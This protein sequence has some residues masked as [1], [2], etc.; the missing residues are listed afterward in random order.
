[1][2][3][4]E[5]AAGPIGADQLGNVLSHEHVFVL[6]PELQ[7][8]FPHEWG[9][10]DARVDDAVDKL[11]RLKSCGID[12]IIDPTAIGLGRYIPRIA[13]IARR[14]PVNIVVATGVYAFNDL[15]MYFRMRPVRDGRDV[16]TKRFVRDIQEGIGGTE[17]KAGVIK[18]ATDRPGLTPDVD[19]TLR[20]VAQA[21]RETGCPITTHTRA[22][23]RTGLLQ[24]A[25]FA[26]EG[27]DLERVLI[28]H[29]GDTDDMDYLHQL[30]EAGSYLGMDRFGIDGY[31][32]HERRIATIV[33][34][35]QE[36]YANRL[37][38]SHDAGCYMDVVDGEDA[39]NELGDVSN[40]HYEFISRTVLPDLLT[41]GVT[42][43]QVDLMMIE[44]PRAYLSNI[45]RGGY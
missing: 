9:D 1:M 44:N 19:R 41:A 35:C 26:S 6:S 25:V 34:L 28:G 18:C 5:T 32:S 22:E 8:N 13:R 43:Q 30:L 4:I 7:Q 45:W 21:H 39:G 12:T 23:E 20:A 42:Q 11:T 33:R 31:I 3:I 15:P 40:W 37:M 36:G 27:V 14:V 16:M 10:E 2:N 24:Q 29:C 17:V 38:L